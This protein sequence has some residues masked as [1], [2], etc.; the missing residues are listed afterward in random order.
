MVK[1]PVQL[2]S[3]IAENAQKIFFNFERKFGQRKGGY[4]AVFSSEATLLQVT[5]ISEGLDFEKESVERKSLILAATP[6][7]ISS[8]QTIAQSKG[9][10]RLNNSL[11]I[12]FACNAMSEDEKEL[13]TLAVARSMRNDLG[14]SKI[15][16][17]GD[18]ISMEQILSIAENQLLSHESINQLIKGWVIS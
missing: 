16:Y 4:L 9:A 1:Y 17:D 15:W 3:T 14:N 18:V 11:I 12:G 10:L 2:I 8:S 6:A 5:R 7:A 13:F